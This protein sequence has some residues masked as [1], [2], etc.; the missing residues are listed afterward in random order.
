MVLD[1]I[2]CLIDIDI[3]NNVKLVFFFY[4]LSKESLDV[5]RRSFRFLIVFDVIYLNYL[6]NIT[7][8]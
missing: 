3:D 6:H 4:T 8:I 1:S 2:T 5:R 7:I